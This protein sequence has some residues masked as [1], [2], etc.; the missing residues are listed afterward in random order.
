[1]Q[2]SSFS[3]SR[4][5]FLPAMKRSNTLF[6]VCF[7]CCLPFLNLLCLADSLSWDFRLADKMSDWKISAVEVRRQQGELWLYGPAQT[8]FL[9]CDFPNGFATE[10]VARIELEFQGVDE[11]SLRLQFRREGEDFNEK[12]TLRFASIC[13]GAHQRV[14]VDCTAH[15]AWQGKITGLRLLPVINNPGIARLLRMRF[16]RTAETILPNGTFEDTQ[17]DNPRLP[18]SWYC[19]PGDGGEVHLTVPGFAGGHALFLKN[20]GAFTAFQPLWPQPYSLT[21]RYRFDKQSITLKDSGTAQ[22]VLQYYDSFDKHVGTGTRK[23][24]GNHHWKQE[25]FQIRVPEE[26]ARVHVSFLADETPLLVDDVAVFPI[27][28]EIHNF[29]NQR[30]GYNWSASQWIWSGE[31][32]STANQTVYFRQEFDIPDP[33]L[34]DRAI[35]QLMTRDLYFCREYQAQVFCNGQEIQPDNAPALTE[36][37]RAFNIKPLLRPG[38]NLLAVASFQRFPSAA[39]QPELFLSGP[40]GDRRLNHETWRSCNTLLPDWNTLDFAQTDKFVEPHVWEEGNGEPVSG[41][42]FCRVSYR[43]PGFAGTLGMPGLSLP[44]EIDGNREYRLTCPLELK[45]GY[46]AE[47]DAGAALR[48]VTVSEDGKVVTRMGRIPLTPKMQRLDFPLVFQYHASGTYSL[49]LYADRVQLTSAPAGFTLNKT[50]NFLEKTIRVTARHHYGFPSCRILGVREGNPEIEV[51][52]QRFTPDRFSSGEFTQRDTEASMQIIDQT[53]Q[54]S[55]PLVACHLGATAHRYLGNGKFDFSA[56]D[57]MLTSI[58]ARHPDAYL[59]L[60]W[61]PDARGSRGSM[62]DWVLEHPEGWTVNS[63]GST[64]IMGYYSYKDNPA[65]S[66]AFAPWQEMMDSKLEQLMEHLKNSAYADRIV[67]I[68]PNYNAENF[69]NGS[70]PNMLIDYCPAF[71]EE[72][73]RWLKGQYRSIALLNAAWKTK[74]AD[75]S[76]IEV[77]DHATR[78]NTRRIDFLIPGENQNVI[79]LHEYLTVL[80]TDCMQKLSDG[81]KRLSDGKLLTGYYYGYT[82][83]C[84]TPGHVATTGHA[85]LE[86]VLQKHDIDFFMHPPRYADRGFGGASGLQGPVAALREQG[87]LV[88]NEADNRIS[89]SWTTAGFTGPIEDSNAVIAREFGFSLATGGAMSWLEFGEGWLSDD[90]RFLDVFRKCREV[91]AQLTQRQIPRIDK[92]NSIAVV[93]D[94]KALKWTPD[95]CPAM[96]PLLNLYPELLRTGCGVQW[97]L[98]QDLERLE[99]YRCIIFTHALTTL[100]QEQRDFLETRLKGNG[101]TLVFLGAAGAYGDGQGDLSAEGVSRLTGLEMEMEEGRGKLN[102]HRCADD[103][104][105]KYL[106]PFYVINTPNVTTPFFHLKRTPET[107]VLFQDQRKPEP[108]ALLGLRRFDDWTA[109]YSQAQSLPAPLL[110]GIAEDAGINIFNPHNGDVTYAAN[111]FHCVYTIDPGPRT[112]NAGI[113]AGTA[114]DLLTGKKY[115]IANGKFSANLRP[116]TYYFLIE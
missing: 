60:I 108:R 63:K 17:W 101:R 87:K 78:C 81:I 92:A 16:L 83:W 7:L 94:E 46:N 64:D 57:N 22:L 90:P 66:F 99:P 45:F 23:L 48:P 54:A 52:G 71:R 104:I 2:F 62:G 21:F 84:L 115:A 32:K 29:N 85:G 82:L 56:M 39:I 91:S 93:Y 49:R 41:G 27:D 69:H 25:Q 89:H 24:A 111:R 4:L 11:G 105:L 14:T 74:Y 55:G 35:F 106:P 102:L 51:N 33:A 68:S 59:E 34:I 43:Y 100:T 37:T 88:Y 75:F 12:H 40:D 19:N 20:A 65:I 1:M 76:E 36:W 79:D 30:R 114:T 28:T 50:A 113:P 96:T 80:M 112:F 10:D 70:M 77:P 53:F 9:M 3:S 116:G 42:Y 95:L 47:L 73:Q 107:K 72:F 31:D 26:V 6:T 98:L 110:R 86:R 38:K 15:P 97:Y 13:G 109:I 8:T 103:D 44:D 67:S 5:K 61:F 58:L 18:D